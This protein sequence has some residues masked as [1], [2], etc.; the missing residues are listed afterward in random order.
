STAFTVP[1][2][3][4]MMMPRVTGKCLTRS[5]TS[6]SAISSDLDGRGPGLGDPV[7]VV[8]GGDVGGPAGQR[9]HL[10]RADVGGE[11]AAGM[12]RAARRHPDEAR[13][14]AGDRPQPL[15]AAPVE[16]GQAG[17]QAQR[18]RVAGSVEE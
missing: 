1:I 3:W 12:E 16:A 18:V 17:Q 13:R 11:R 7:L 14:L 2:W 10:L 4:R 6:S 8:A 9:G 15:G 5:V